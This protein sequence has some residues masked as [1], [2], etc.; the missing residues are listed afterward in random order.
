MSGG[1][2]P[3]GPLAVALEHAAKLLAGNPAAAAEQAGE[4]L[5]V[6][7]GH[8]VAVLLMGSAQRALGNATHAVEFLAPLARQQP[9][10]AAAHLELGLALGAAGQGDAAVVALRHALKLNPALPDAWRALG[11]HLT[12]GG[13]T[14]GADAAYAQQIRYS[15][16]DPRLVQ[17]A[18]AL[19]DNEIPQAEALLREHLKQH[20]TDIVAI[21]MFAEVAAR[22]ERYTDAQSLLERCLELAPGF[23]AARRNYATVLHRQYKDAEA[24]EQA[25]RLLAIDPTDPTYRNLKAAILGGLG[26]YEE[27]IELYAGILARYPQQEKV[28]LNYGHALKTAGRQQDS[29]DAYRK[30]IALAPHCGAACWSLANLKTFRFSSDEVEAMRTQLARTDLAEDD[31]VHF[32]FAA[33]KAFEDAKT[34]DVSFEH[35]ARANSLRRAQLG[36]DADRTSARV[37]R[38]QEI[39]TSAFFEQRRGY[40]AEAPDPVFI[41]GLPR[42]GSTLLEQILA[43]HSAVEGTMELPDLISIARKLTG[44]SGSGARFPESLTSLSAAECRALGEQYIRQTRV[45]RR[46]AAPFFIDK[47]PNNFAYVGFIQL[48]LPNAKIIDARRHPLGCCLS[49][50]KQH[51]ARGQSFAYD[52]EDLGRYYR[53]YVALMSHFDEALPGR[54]HRVIYETVVENTEAEVRRLLDYCGLPFEAQ[55]LRFYDNARAVR[56]A[57]SEQVRQPIFRDAMEHWRHYEPWLDPLKR[58]LGPVLESY[59]TPEF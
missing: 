17:A 24:L 55:C 46:T 6:V 29:I 5:K 33:G 56:T 53:D 39:L 49:V 40:G 50:F 20:P 11:D 21:R 14:T 3:V 48:V 32:E 38:C 2:E 41:V 22:L 8:P 25:D 13:D 19:H 59:P 52:L 28:W 15:T 4:I 23:A 58:A 9:H 51:F 42:A 12:V 44:T 54:V 47:M 35:Y 36:Y 57:S 10:W 1:S 30:C 45:Q 37:R 27:S 43:S 16:Q 31:R 18:I 26:R 34:Y 7:P